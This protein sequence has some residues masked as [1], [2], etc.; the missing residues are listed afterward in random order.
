MHADKKADF[1]NVTA[2][3]DSTAEIVQSPEFSNVRSSVESTAQIVGEQSVTVQPGDSLSLIAK[4]H[5]G[6]G[7]LWPRLFEA[8]RATLK[9]PDLLQ[10][11]QVLRLPPKA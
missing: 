3:V 11:G 2:T 1:S 10:P 5:Y 4:R 8:N 7:N 9:D 6:D